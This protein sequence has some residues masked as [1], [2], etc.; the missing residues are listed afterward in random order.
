MNLN[1]L[2][3]WLRRALALL[4]LTAAISAACTAQDSRPLD[5]LP[6]APP[7]RTIPEA[8]RTQLNDVRDSKS[9]IKKT[10]GF[11]D[12]HL[13]R[14]ESA[15]NQQQFDLS[16]RELGNYLGLFED[17]FR[18][19]AKLNAGDSGKSR[20]LYKHIEL[21]LRSHGPRLTVMRRATPLEYAMRMKEVEDYAREG[22]TDALNAFYGNTVVRETSPRK[23]E[24]KPKPTPPNPER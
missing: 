13:L 4:S 15:A 12:A 18:F 14:A 21:A 5:Q 6:A 22:R 20:D 3:K 16:L 1:T 17:A 23:P 9:R 10:V 19:I 8:E 24:Q 7:M 2:D 11:A